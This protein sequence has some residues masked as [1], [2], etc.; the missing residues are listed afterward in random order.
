MVRHKSIIITDHREQ[1]NFHRISPIK[2]AIWNGHADRPQVPKS[3]YQRKS[4]SLLGVQENNEQRKET[5]TL[6]VI[7]SSDDVEKFGFIRYFIG[8]SGSTVAVL[9]RLVPSPLHCY[10]PE[11]SVLQSRII[12]VIPTDDIDIVCISFIVN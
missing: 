8:L 10:P 3:P 9:Y 7:H 2:G 1:K 6:Y 4:V 5:V 11:I 12:P